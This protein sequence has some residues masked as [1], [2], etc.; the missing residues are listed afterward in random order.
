MARCKGGNGRGEGWDG[1]EAGSV[2]TYH[3]VGVSEGRV[4]VLGRERPRG[5]G[6]VWV[7]ERERPRGRGEGKGFNK[8][9]KERFMGSFCWDRRHTT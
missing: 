5:R 1:R 7:R 6:C 2:S 8:E 4:K 3:T 9:E